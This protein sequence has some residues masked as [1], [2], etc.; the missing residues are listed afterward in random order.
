MNFFL[1]TRVLLWTVAILVLLN[2][3]T[4]IGVLSFSN[5]EPSSEK[6]RN[7]F[8][9]KLELTESQKE[10]FISRKAFYKKINDPLYDRYDTIMVYLQKQIA[11]Q[12]TDTATIRLYTDSLGYLN[13][14]IRRNWLRYSIE[15]RTYLNEAQQKK[16]DV[17][18]MEHL[19]N[20][21]SK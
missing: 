8:F 19:K 21:L 20:R 10:K 11:I 2:I 1:K 9:K 6:Q 18:T 7:E 13:A 3:A 12:P 14:E 15:V 16:Y 5:E 17:L 4:F